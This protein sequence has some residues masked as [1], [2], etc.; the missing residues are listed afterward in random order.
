MVNFLVGC[1]TNLSPDFSAFGNN[2]MITTQ[3]VFLN[4]GYRCDNKDPPLIWI[5][6][7][8]SSYNHLA[9]DCF[10]ISESKHATILN[11]IVP[12]SSS[13]REYLIK[14]I[15]SNI[16]NININVNIP[17]IDFRFHFQNSKYYIGSYIVVNP[18]GPNWANIAFIAPT[19]HANN[20]LEIGVDSEENCI[21]I[22]P[23]I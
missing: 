1:F 13:Y 19:L 18:S 11:N 15:R 23:Y 10:P 20:L 17:R 14:D 2:T 12:S 8:R 22:L 9:K 6:S 7:L 16:P 3:P 21:L 4:K 5:D